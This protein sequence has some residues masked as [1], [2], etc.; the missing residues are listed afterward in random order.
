MRP[1]FHTATA[2]T[3]AAALVCGCATPPRPGSR[4]TSRTA[5]T[6]VHAGCPV[7]LSKA[8]T[9]ELVFGRNIGERLGVSEDDWKKFLDEDVTPRFPEGLS[10]VDVQGQWRASNGALVREPSKA[11]YLILDG[12]PDD[13]AKIAHIRDAYKRR[14]K[15]EAVLLVTHS[16]CVSF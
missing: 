5:S 14:F 6:P 1:A 10:V 12:G 3:L 13:A 2:L 9:A 7:G 8:T 11:L 4:A 15:Q 16:A